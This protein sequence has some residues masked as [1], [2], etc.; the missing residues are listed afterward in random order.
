MASTADAAAGWAIYRDADFALSLDEINDRLVRH[1]CSPVSQRMYRHYGKLQRYGYERYVPI[2]QLDVKTLLDPFVDQ[3]RRGREHPIQTLAEVE[4]RVLVDDEIRGFAG[5]AIE[6]SSTEVVVRLAGAEMAAFFSELGS[7]T[8]AGAVVFTSTG[9][10]RIGTIERLT[11]DVEQALS[12]VRVDFSGQLD[13]ARLV[14]PAIPSDE[15]RLALRIGLPP[16]LGL[17]EVARQLYWLAQACDA[18]RASASDLAQ[19]LA[20]GEAV[21]IGIV[22]V[23]SLRLSSIEIVIGVPAG[24]GLVL[25]GAF[26]GWLKIRQAYWTSEKTKQEAIRL[27]WENEQADLRGKAD[28]AP[29]VRRA[30]AALSRRLRQ[31]GIDPSEGV[32]E[33]R[34]LAIAQK[35]LLPA[36]AEIVEAADGDVDVATEGDISEQVADE[37]GA[38]RE[39]PTSG[40]D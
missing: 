32:D 40:E 12:T 33:T 26:W 28:L 1:G 31:S 27:R 11:L 21:D 15:L 9:E 39:L 36:V 4:L 22:K 29:L 8:P 19:Q 3:A 13:V 30:R 35:Q 2:N 5:T 34:A 20:P 6:L 37:L 38:A 16:S 14:Q 18:A 25:Y 17:T 24:A 7:A 10:I 23:R